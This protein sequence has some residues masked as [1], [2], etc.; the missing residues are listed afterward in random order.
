MTDRPIAKTL[1]ARA[2]GATFPSVR[3]LPDLQVAT[4]DAQG[5][6]ALRSAATTMCW[7]PNDPVTL[8]VHDGVLRLT[9]PTISMAGLAVLLDSR[10]RVQLPYGIRTATG[11]EPGARLMIVAA[12]H[13]GV[14]A[15]LA[16]SRVVAAFA[17]RP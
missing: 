17:A 7:Q 10:C 11:L 2:P 15:A 9:D 16:V 12:P 6:L 1:P 13:E 8:T 3:T 14:V 5:R 4:L